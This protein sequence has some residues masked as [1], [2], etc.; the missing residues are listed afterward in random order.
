MR[1][2]QQIWKRMEGHHVEQHME[3]DRHT[4]HRKE[5]YMDTR[6][7]EGMD[8]QKVEEEELLL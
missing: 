4:I 3:E 1:E 7:E 8:K 2:E 6:M 5:Y